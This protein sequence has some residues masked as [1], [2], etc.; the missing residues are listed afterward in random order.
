MVSPAETA[1]VVVVG[2]GAAGSLAAA[3]LSAAGKHVIV[4]EA[5][6]AWTLKDLVSSQIWARRLKW[7]GSPVQTAGSAP[8]G[9]NMA[10]G[11]GLGGS[12]L[13]HYAN[14]PRLTPDDF[15]LKTRFGHGADW[16]ISYED[17][18]PFYDQIQDEVGLSGDA[19]AEVWRPEGKAYPHPAFP[20]FPQAERLARGFTALGMRTAPTPLAILTQER[21]GRQACIYDG[22]CDAGCPI[23]ALANP[24]VT[25]QR[26][27]VKAGAVIRAHAPVTRILTDDRGRAVGVEWVDQTG[28]VRRVEAGEVI[29]AASAIQ[30]PR[31][32]LAS[33]SPKHPAGLGNDHDLV[34][35]GFM[36]HALVGLFGLFDQAL[37]N[38][39]GVPGG[40][41]VCRDGAGKTAAAGAFGGREWVI[42]AALKPNDLI[43]IAMTRPD[44]FGE[45]LAQFMTKDAK[46]LGNMGALIETLPRPDN[47]VELTAARDAHGTPLAK[48]THSLGPE[49]LA[50]VEH[51]R[52]EGQAIL[53]AAGAK[54]AWAS[55][56]ITNHAL[57]GTPMGTD[58][59]NSVTDSL[60]RVW[61]TPNLWIMGGGL[62]PTIGAGGP[63]FTIHALGLRAVKAMLGH[64]EARASAA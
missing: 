59:T 13:H 35:R 9:H 55:P 16:P 41:L 36:A 5:G 54:A 24:L 14:W 44:L 48:V 18:R 22:W 15:R 23:G 46:T 38:H 34:G 17:L 21:P 63:T 1:D 30:T 62:F 45:R 27:A 53:K 33:T 29:L 6:P 10:V 37:D 2:A 43:G 28:A 7:G 50:R 31:L 12:A 20:T 58:P 11:W 47:R 57:G 8:F 51:A 25:Y 4:L 56:L 39:L 40:N 64:G 3:K 49:T 52:T 32:L 60:G 61:N 42:G 19:A 26:D